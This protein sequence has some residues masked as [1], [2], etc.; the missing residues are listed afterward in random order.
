MRDSDSLVMP[1]F[2]VFKI[3]R[4]AIAIS[5]I[6]VAKESITWGSKKE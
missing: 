3:I 1:V 6:I 5:N 4:I 2:P